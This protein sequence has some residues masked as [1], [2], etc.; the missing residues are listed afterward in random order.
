[1]AYF[2]TRSTKDEAHVPIL[3]F[4]FFQQAFLNP[5]NK[6]YALIDMRR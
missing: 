2:P 4:E 3:S 5:V 6:I 1:M